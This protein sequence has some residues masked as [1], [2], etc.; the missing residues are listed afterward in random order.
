[1]ARPAARMAWRSA[2]ASGSSFP[3]ARTWIETGIATRVAAEPHSG[4]STAGNHRAK[5]LPISSPARV[6][7]SRGARDSGTGIGFPSD[8]G[9][10][11]LGDFFLHDAA[12]RQCVEGLGLVQVEEGIVATG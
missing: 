7:P 6:T 5:R 3:M 10:E 2:A 1:M 4:Y 8:T 11:R 9:G 12:H